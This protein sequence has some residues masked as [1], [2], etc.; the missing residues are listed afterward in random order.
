MTRNAGF[1]LIELLIVVALIGILAALCAPF[2]LAA[3]AASSEASAIGTL[4]AINSAQAS[5]AS[6]CGRNYYAPVLQTLINGGHLD[7][8][9]ALA[10]KSSYVT[11]L[12][13]GLAAA[14]GT[15]DC[16]GQ[17]TT[18]TYYASATPIGGANATRAFASS[19][20][21]TVWQ[22]MTGVAPTEPFTVSPTVGPI[23]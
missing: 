22:D 11:A 7:Q 1:T 15:P 12:G 3:K 23:Q 19:Q 4:R 18:T 2:L 20:G 5:Y 9:V 14:A 13:P 10:P 8:D 21:G 17:A 16:T 6:G